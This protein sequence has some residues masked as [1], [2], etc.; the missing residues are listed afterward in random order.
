M[1]HV[2]AFASKTALT[3]A[4][5]YIVLDLMY[6]VTFL[7]VLFITLILSL[8]TYFLGDCMILPRTSNFTA[9]AADF[10]ISFI[11]LWIFLMNIGGFNVSP[12]AASVISAFCLSVF[13]AFFHRYL[14]QFVLPEDYQGETGTDSTQLRYQTEASEE[15]MPEKD[16][17]EKT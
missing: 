16:S 4:L 12:A 9:V 15:L 14:Q 6:Q 7:N 17:E 1:K 8:V 13:E 2:I 5:L 3:L 10:G 11:I